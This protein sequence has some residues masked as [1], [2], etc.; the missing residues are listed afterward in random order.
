MRKTKKQHEEAIVEV[1]RQHPDVTFFADIFSYY[2]D[3]TERHAYRLKCQECQSIKDALRANCIISKRDMRKKWRESDSATL[4]IAAY[5]LMAD[6]E[7]LRK[8]NQQYIESRQHV[9]LQTDSRT[10]EEI[11]DEINRLGALEDIARKE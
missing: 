5:R 4:Q 2:P 7:E 9:K 1:I 11:V 3:L 6:E 8:L 10:P